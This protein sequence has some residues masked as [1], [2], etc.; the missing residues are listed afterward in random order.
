MT[1]RTTL[2]TAPKPQP[3]GKRPR[4]LHC[5]KELEPQFTEP[6]MPAKLRDGRRHAERKTW[7][8]ANP[9][10]FTGHYGRFRDNR[11]CGASCGYNWAIAHAPK[12][13]VAA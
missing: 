5:T 6:V 13:K 8:K 2:K 4:C 7:E 3:K 12:K 10:Q 9:A 11:F 1:R